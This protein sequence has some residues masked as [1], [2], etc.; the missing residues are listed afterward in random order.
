MLMIAGFA[1]VDNAELYMDRSYN[2]ATAEGG[3]TAA[4]DPSENCR[5]SVRHG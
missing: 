3:S 4:H 2:H 5:K 1:L